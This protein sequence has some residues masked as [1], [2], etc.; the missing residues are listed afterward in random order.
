MDTSRRHLLQATRVAGGATGPVL[1]R[2]DRS[3]WMEEFVFGVKATSSS[4]VTRTWIEGYDFLAERM[5][6]LPEME[7]EVLAA[8]K[9]RFKQTPPWSSV[10]GSREP[11]GSPQLLAPEEKRSTLTVHVSLCSFPFLQ[12][13]SCRNPARFGVA[14]LR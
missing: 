9:A 14:F 11:H 12:A 10:G 7:G 13:S 3:L 1:G 4:E 5:A 2:V 6:I 8:W